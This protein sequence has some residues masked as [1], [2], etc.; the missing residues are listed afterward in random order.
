MQVCIFPTEREVDVEVGR[1]IAEQIR[2]KPD[3]V[4]G[5]A[6]G[7]TP[8]GIYREL[9]RLHRSEALSFRGIKA[10]NLD[11][12]A[13]LPADHPQSYACYMKEN[14]FKDIDILPAN[15]YIPNGLAEDMERECRDYEERYRSVG[16][17]DL[18]LLG[19]GLNGHIGFNEPGSDLTAA[20]SLVRLDASTRAANARFFDRP[21]QVPER[22]ITMGIGTILQARSIVLAVTGSAKAAIL[23]DALHGE[24]T[25][26]CPASILQAHDN[27]T[28]VADL[29]ASALLQ[30]DRR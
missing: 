29:A 9:I 10:F 7:G 4:L 8:I 24:V 18:Q 3:S 26:L 2:S 23:R 12:Y 27:V 17:A 16:P 13:G 25:S 6:T 15:C 30:L 1:R 21:E 14:L 11:E 22:A 28:V 20:T 5:L 19:I